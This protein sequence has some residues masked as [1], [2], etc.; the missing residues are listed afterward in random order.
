[1]PKALNLVKIQK[2][3]INMRKNFDW[4]V[5]FYEVTLLFFF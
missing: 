2:N 3:V 1:M 5:Q 4:F